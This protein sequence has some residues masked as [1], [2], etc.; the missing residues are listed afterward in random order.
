MQFYI[1]D[2]MSENVVAIEENETIQTL[3]NILA[4]NDISA[5]PVVDRNGYISGVVSISDVVKNTSSL[6]FYRASFL[7]PLIL[8]ID[9][10]KSI[11]KLPVSSI[12]T[13]K[14]FSLPP[15]ATV[16]EMAKIMYENKIH[17]L[18]VIENKKLIGIVSTFDLLKLIATS[19]DDF[20]VD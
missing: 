17:R 11:F 6:E 12:M 3:V 16:S 15:N 4:K 9:Q 20:I 10:S 1:K 5:V 8:K 2:I 19:D 7:N 13:N 14:L 18:L